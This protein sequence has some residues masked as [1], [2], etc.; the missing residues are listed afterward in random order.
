MYIYNPLGENPTV[1]SSN[2]T[3]P[4][5]ANPAQAILVASAHTLSTSYDG[6]TIYPQSGTMTGT[7]TLYGLKEV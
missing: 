5:G 4:R 6:V 7:I 3:T 1:L 2:G